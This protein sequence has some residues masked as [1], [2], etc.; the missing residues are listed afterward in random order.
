MYLPKKPYERVEKKNFNRIYN[1]KI[2]YVNKFQTIILIFV[3]YV[4]FY[5]AKK[6]ESTMIF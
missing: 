2:R 6:K 3:K 4:F 1:V 5:L